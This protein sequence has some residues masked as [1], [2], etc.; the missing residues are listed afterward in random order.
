MPPDKVESDAISDPASLNGRI[1]VADIYPGGQ[2]TLNNFTAEASGALNAQIAGLQRAVS[3]TMDP[4]RGSL[5][6]V[7]N[8]D[9]VDIY[10]QLTREGRLVI[11]LFRSNVEV[12][13]APGSAGGTVVLRVPTGDAANVLYA[14]TQ[15]TLYFV[16]RP[17]SGA[18][19]SAK[20]LADLS[21][22]IATSGVR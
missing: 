1:A 22:V 6:N 2:L 20:R 10:T 15:T 8:G 21:T 18:S 16:V 9:H 14:A 7:A 17:A 19:P 13:Q 5:A 12:M 11:Q 3:L 4:V